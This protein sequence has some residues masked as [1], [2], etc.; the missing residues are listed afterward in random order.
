[1]PDLDVDLE[2]E[3]EADLEPDEVEVGPRTEERQAYTTSSLGED[4][5]AR[6]HEFVDA[7]NS[8]MVAYPEVLSVD[9]EFDGSELSPY[10]WYGTLRKPESGIDFTQGASSRAKELL[11][12]SAVMLLYTARVAN[13]DLDFEAFW[14][15]VQTE[16]G[17]SLAR[18]AQRSLSRF[19]KPAGG[20]GRILKSF[21][22]DHDDDTALEQAE[23]RLRDV[24]GRL[25]L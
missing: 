14:D 5:S 12:S 23:C 9:A 19:S 11:F 7:M 2:L 6:A 10:L 15:W 8:L 21:G 24:W 20:G 17:P 1:M 4:L 3:E 25:G 13:S 16:N 22:E 18:R